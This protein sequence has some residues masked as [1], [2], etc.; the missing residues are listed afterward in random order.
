MLGILFGTACLIGMYAVVRGRRFG[1]FGRLARGPHWGGRRGGWLGWLSERLDATPGQ[2]KAIKAAIDEL[3]EPARGLRSEAS[4][5]RGDVARAMRG[6]YFDETVM[7][8]MFARHDSALEELR[9]AAVGAL[10]RV[11][12]VLDDEQRAKLA[13]LVETG[14][15]FSRF[16]HFGHAHGTSL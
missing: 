6:D 12:A 2:E 15:R 16:G 10:A 13:N 4:A 8:D 1:R 3:K 5:L 9:K 11:H 14:P 7:G